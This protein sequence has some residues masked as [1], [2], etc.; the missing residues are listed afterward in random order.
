MVNYMP[1]KNVATVVEERGPVW[2][3]CSV[4]R[5]VVYPKLQQLVLVRDT[6]PSMDFLQHYKGL[7]HLHVEGEF[8]EET[9]GHFFHGKILLDIMENLK[10]NDKLNKLKVI[11]CK[12][13]SWGIIQD[14]IIRAIQRSM[15]EYFVS[16]PRLR[17]IYISLY[18]VNDEVF[19]TIMDHCSELEDLTLR[20]QDFT[21]GEFTAVLA[22]KQWLLLTSL[23]LTDCKVL[24]DACLR[25][26]PV[27]FPNLKCLKLSLS[28]TMTD[29]GMEKLLRECCQLR[30]LNLSTLFNTSAGIGKLT[31]CCLKELAYHGN[32][33]SLYLHNFDLTYECDGWDFEKLCQRQQNLHTIELSACDV[34]NSTILAMADHCPLLHSV[35]MISCLGLTSGQQAV[36]LARLPHLQTL[37][38]DD[39]RSLSEN[40][41]EKFSLEDVQERRPSGEVM[42]LN[43]PTEQHSSSLHKPSLDSLT[44]NCRKERMAGRKLA[45]PSFFS[46]LHLDVTMHTSGELCDDLVARILGMCPKLQTLSLRLNYLKKPWQRETRLTEASLTHIQELGRCLRTVQLLTFRSFSDA[47]LAQ[48]LV[49]LPQL[50]QCTVLCPDQTSNDSVDQAMLRDLSMALKER[51]DGVPLFFSVGIRTYKFLPNV[52]IF[53]RRLTT[54]DILI[55]SRMDLNADFQTLMFT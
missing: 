21:V 53:D 47:A 37:Y 39:A 28:K 2:P 44:L 36:L 11:F 43:Q 32:L 12:Y 10:S 5:D 55:H 22:K 34:K 40:G 38:W 30:S 16:G 18:M 17:E 31:G 54:L 13:F 3:S 20:C 23:R 7:T 50:R 41:S 4:T 1:V 14:D 15:V 9:A 48:T 45:L 51:G 19:R 52:A 8:E 6:L 29:D 27:A 49:D 42:L 24:D 46:L 35:K 25:A 33:H 26:L